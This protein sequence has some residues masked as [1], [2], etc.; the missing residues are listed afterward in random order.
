MC[1]EGRFRWLWFIAVF[2][3]LGASAAGAKAA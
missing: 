3:G 2:E 1:F